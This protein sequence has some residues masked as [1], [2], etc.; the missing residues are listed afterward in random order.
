MNI[1][2]CFLSITKDHFNLEELKKQAKESKLH[3][4]DIYEYIENNDYT[5]NVEDKTIYYSLYHL[6]KKY[7][8]N[9]VH[10]NIWN[11]IGDKAGLLFLPLIDL[12]TNHKDEYDM[13]LFYEDDVSYFGNENLFD[14]I[15]LNTDV[16]FQDRRI[17]VDDDHWA[18]WYDER[19][20]RDTKID[21]EII[22]VLYHGLLNFYALKSNVIADFIKF[23]K[24]NYAYYELLI[25]AFVLN[26]DYK[27]NYAND[28]V[29]T[30]S[31]FSDD[32]PITDEFLLVHP[33]K[34]IEK[35]NLIKSEIKI[36]E[37]L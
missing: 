14:T 15:D 28:Y 20:N 31:S 29:K 4:I 10:T 9:Y 3:N 25:P 22:K 32:A 34:T 5:Y 33:I 36:K 19:L 21:R 23:I 1:A 16:V 11:K 35:Y 30:Y 27:V 2:V 12:Y 17:T 24:D 26:N 18:W 13:F 8:W 6:A 37:N 7:N